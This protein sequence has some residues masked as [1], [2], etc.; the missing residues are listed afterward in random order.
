MRSSQSLLRNFVLLLLLY[1]PHAATCSGQ[2]PSATVEFDLPQGAKVT[3]QGQTLQLDVPWIV[4][5][6]Q[7]WRHYRLEIVLPDGSAHR[8]E[9]LLEPGATVRVA[10][11]SKARHNSRIVLQ[12]GHAAGITSI[13]VSSDGM[14][15]LT[16]SVDHTAILWRTADERQLLTFAGHDQAAVS[17]AFAPRSGIAMTGGSDGKA[18]VWDLLRNTKVGEPLTH[19]NHVHLVRFNKKGD[20]ALTIAGGDPHYG[21]EG[22][23]V[24]WDIAKAERIQEFKDGLYGIFWAE[25]SPDEKQVVGASYQRTL[26]WDVATGD[27]LR[28]WA[29]CRFASFDVTGKLLI[30]DAG[31]L[32]TD[33]NALTVTFEYSGKPSAVAM[34]H[35]RTLYAVGTDDGEVHIW[36]IP[37]GKKLLNVKQS[38]TINA[39]AFGPNNAILYIASNGS[40]DRPSLVTRCRWTLKP[41]ANTTMFSESTRHGSPDAI[42]GAKFSPGGIHVVARHQNHVT[43]W[44]HDVG[45]TARHLRTPQ[46]LPTS[47]AL[48]TNKH[49]LAI[50]L[51]R[52]NSPGFLR[53]WDRDNNRNSLVYR[54]TEGSIR[55][56]RASGDG[57]K[58]A[59]L[60][61]GVAKWI[62]QATGEVIASLAVPQKT[63]SAV[64]CTNEFMLA[65]WHGSDRKTQIVSMGERASRTIVRPS[66]GHVTALACNAMRR[67]AITAIATATDDESLSSRLEAWDADSG[68][69]LWTSDEYHAL[70]THIAI[71]KSGERILAGYADGTVCCHSVEDGCEL[72]ELQTPG[73]IN[74]GS[75]EFSFEKGE[76]KRRVLAAS[77][78]RANKRLALAIQN[79]EIEREIALELWDIES[80]QMLRSTQSP[81]AVR[82]MCLLDDGITVVVVGH[83]TGVIDPT[84]PAQQF[85]YAATIDLFAGRVLQVHKWSSNV[86][87]SHCFS[88]A[89][90]R[91][92][93]V[94][95]TANKPFVVDLV[96]GKTR[97]LTLPL[98]QPA[99]EPDG[100][101]CIA[102]SGNSDR[103]LGGIGNIVYE[104][105]NRTLGAKSKLVHP[106][107][108][109]VQAIAI[110]PDNS[111]CL[112]MAASTV[113]RWN[114]KD[115]RKISDFKCPTGSFVAVAYFQG[116]PAA[117]SNE[118]GTGRLRVW[119]L[120][121]ERWLH[122]LVGVE[123]KVQC[124][125]V[126]DGGRL[127]FTAIA[128]GRSV[129]WDATKGTLLKE[130]HS[131]GKRLK[132]RNAQ[133]YVNAVSAASFAEDE[134]H[135]AVT[136]GGTTWVTDVGR[137]RDVSYEESGGQVVVWNL[138]TSQLIFSMPTIC[139][140][141]I[142]RAATFGADAGQLITVGDGNRPILVWNYKTARPVADMKLP[143]DG[144]FC[145]DAIL[146]PDGKVLSAGG[147]N[148]SAGA[149]A[150]YDLE[151]GTLKHPV[152]D[153]FS[154][155]KHVAFSADGSRLASLNSSGEL[156][157]FELEPTI[158]RLHKNKTKSYGASF[159]PDGS[160][161][162]TNERNGA[163]IWSAETGD[164]LREVTGT[165]DWPKGS[166]A[167][168][169][170]RSDLILLGGG[171][172]YG[173]GELSGRFTPELRLFRVSDGALVR[174]F[175]GSST[176]DRPHFAGHRYNV[177]AVAFSKN[178]PL[179]VSGAAN[180]EI[181]VWHTDGEILR[182][183]KDQCG[184]ISSVDFDEKGR[185][186]LSTAADAT[187]RLWDLAEGTEQLRLYS[188]QAGHDWAA[189]TPDG[190]FDG[191]LGGREAA[192]FTRV[193]DG[194]LESDRMESFFAALYRVGLTSR[195]CDDFRPVPR[196]AFGEG[197]RPPSLRVVRHERT[198]ID[199]QPRV[200]LEVEVQEHGGGS[201]PP[202]IFRGERRVLLTSEPTSVTTTRRTSRW[203]FELQPTAGADRIEIR[204]TR[205]DGLWA[206]E[207]AV[208]ILRNG[209][210]SKR[211]KLQVVAIGA[212]L[213]REVDHMADKSAECVASI[214]RDSNNELFSDVEITL[215]S[216]AQHSKALPSRERV[217][218]ELARLSQESRMEDTLV[219]YIC[220]HGASDEQR[221]YVQLISDVKNDT[222]SGRL[223]V[224]E[225]GE[226]LSR[227]PCANRLLILDTCY[228]GQGAKLDELFA[229][230]GAIV[231]A[232]QTTGVFALA[233][234]ANRLSWGDPSLGVT[235][236]ALAL[237][238]SAGSSVAGEAL[239]ELERRAPDRTLTSF[240]WCELAAKNVTLI[241]RSLGFRSRRQ[242][243]QAGSGS[244][245]PLLG[246]RDP[247]EEP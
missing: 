218:Q 12:A 139:E 78:D 26:L 100:F 13:D 169:S 172:S 108:W 47:A 17:A 163:T 148:G 87:P 180:G 33:A 151:S 185:Y 216:S 54:G 192:C 58:I 79:N 225:L 71:S 213:P 159:S 212:K 234:V 197:H 65:A 235:T 164:K 124:C 53:T 207:P 29:Q 223:Y 30:T 237:Q 55:S 56:I 98:H 178:K 205:A 27:V 137:Y 115:P 210:P 168:F 94:G 119:S 167:S 155:V 176:L 111:E 89:D 74:N 37:E 63:L 44:T 90:A 21:G 202:R 4:P 41:P 128:G 23:A 166:A 117:I 16:T 104:L 244:A 246:P 46:S 109:F 82:D 217:V 201:V 68:R 126:A 52:D 99:L 113:F 228:A 194:K 31:I 57:S 59:L 243:V 49:Q 120:S 6:P 211:G 42:A 165:V 25:L 186:V 240:D 214:F 215:L 136:H 32:P 220:S 72:V 133:S 69:M 132:P 187:A 61:D 93:L 97:S 38:G 45:S 122:D 173:R 179:V 101:D 2:S 123:G 157:V 196:D 175:Q 107:Q 230:R 73:S 200:H 103:L 191:S 20:R 118:R 170:P 85:S 66:G 105:Q 22:A 34:S 232:E 247:A 231:Q 184:A 145:H 130:L 83:S 208:S 190:L 242:L 204:C 15:L 238:A 142:V 36:K 125:E 114:L 233:A 77:F 80:A 76:G 134:A 9:L 181:I 206:S 160:M 64:N 158:H 70:C 14:Q 144:E 161:V 182:R 195:I 10:L 51:D 48:D 183:F 131:S 177:T 147:G 91:P 50:G 149:I 127:V 236:L 67:C 152:F 5:A 229:Y 8:R 39:I 129:L 140:D 92:L 121:E 102:Q 239:A 222:A 110:S 43:L 60:T 116:Q 3:Y 143:N 188:F 203:K 193:E 209:V 19:S 24:L 28:S 88:G 219:V 84:S 174:E 40:A 138:D 18:I 162:L 95:S 189:F 75:E 81:I 199:N 227:I 226:S 135:V 11:P 224:D 156:E 141:Q 146:L 112:T 171:G 154:G 35:D 221:Y 7:P 198:T 62:D 96:G 86:V 1:A 150:I 106:D 241:N 153:V 245:F